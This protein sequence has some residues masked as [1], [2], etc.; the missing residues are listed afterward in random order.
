MRR[1]VIA[2]KATTQMTRNKAGI[3]GQQVYLSC[4]RCNAKRA[5]L[6]LL[7]GARAR[8]S[9]FA[10]DGGIAM[11]NSALGR[12]IYRR[13]E[14]VDIVRGRIRFGRAFTQSPN[15][16]QDTTIAKSSALGLA[17]TFGSGFGVGHAIK[18]LRAGASWM[19]SYLST[20]QPRGRD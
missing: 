5:R 7:A 15:T 8:Q 20:C 6:P 2:R 19:R 17:R 11:N 14:C 10:T 9:G 4:A 12:F 1:P 18:K 3:I 16:T 13:N